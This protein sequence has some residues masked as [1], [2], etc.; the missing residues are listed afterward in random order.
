MN[1]LIKYAVC[2]SAPSFYHGTQRIAPSIHP[3]WEE[4]EKQPGGQL[5]MVVLTHS[6]ESFIG[7]ADPAFQNNQYRIHGI[8]K[9]YSVIIQVWH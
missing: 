6:P 2:G 7:N 9:Q 4:E 8:S 5:Y 3:L 1:L